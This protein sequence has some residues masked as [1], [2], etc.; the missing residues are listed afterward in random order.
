MARIAVALG[1]DFEDSEFS[2]PQQYLSNHGHEL[3]IFGSKRGQTVHGKRRNAE[4]MVQATAKELRPE[5]FDALLIPGGYSP[6][7]L[8]LDEDVVDFVHRFDETGK[9]MA[10]ICHG[11]QLLIEAETVRDRT[12]TSWPSVRADLINAGARWKDEQVVVD[13]NLITSRKPDDLEAFCEAL[14][15]RLPS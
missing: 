14:Q 9:P 5:E 2:V 8:R 4:A 3:T 11:P 12:M 6:D 13:R 1:E 15:E 7:H 10:V